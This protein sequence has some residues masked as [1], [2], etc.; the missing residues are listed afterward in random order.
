MV[1]YQ[2]APGGQ[3]TGEINLPG[4]KSISHRACILAAIAENNSELINFLPGEDN[5]H[6]LKALHA[7]GV[8]IKFYSKN[9]LQINDH[10][11]LFS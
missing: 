3:L 8:E 2:V 7:L 4:D 9:H 10:L 1:N 11:N 5:L 6:T